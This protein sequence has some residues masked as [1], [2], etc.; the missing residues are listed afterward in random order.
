MRARFNKSPTKEDPG[1]NGARVSRR[2]GEGLRARGHPTRRYP[3]NAQASRR[4]LSARLFSRL[5][6]SVTCLTQLN[7]TL[8]RRGMSPSL[9]EKP[10]E[11]QQHDPGNRIRCLFGAARR[12][13][14]RNPRQMATSEPAGKS[15]ELGAVSPPLLPRERIAHLSYGRRLLRSGFQF[16]LRRVGVI[17]VGRTQPTT[18]PHVR[19]AAGQRYGGPVGRLC[20]LEIVH[21]CPRVAEGYY[22]FGEHQNR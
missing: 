21:A 17:R 11:A 18:S 8:W 12:A 2:M 1:A 9:R 14:L 7:L 13:P 15:D 20:D 22:F 16:A 3:F 10:L 4:F 19:R 6:P 5:S